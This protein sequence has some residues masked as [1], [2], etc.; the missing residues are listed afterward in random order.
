MGERERGD[1]D[2]GGEWRRR[3]GDA[4]GDPINFKSRRDRLVPRLT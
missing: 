3:E 2:Y 4:T 1:G